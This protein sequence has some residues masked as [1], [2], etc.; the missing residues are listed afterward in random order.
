[1]KKLLNPENDAVVVS[2]RKFLQYYLQK[3]GWVFAL[4]IISL[5]ICQEGT[6]LGFVTNIADFLLNKKKSFKVSETKCFWDRI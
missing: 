6:T 4:A 1:V 5:H 3:C 2:H